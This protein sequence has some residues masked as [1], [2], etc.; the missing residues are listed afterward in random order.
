MTNQQHTAFNCRCPDCT[1]PASP[2]APA[3]DTRK[4][5]EVLRLHISSSE[6]MRQT[7]NNVGDKHGE[8][9]QEGITA[10]LER[11]IEVADYRAA[12]APE[13]VAQLV[14]TGETGPDEVL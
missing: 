2:V 12:P 11:A 10:G 3:P 5:Q 6:S 1:P 4:I 13:R 7:F 8:A 14:A 9:L